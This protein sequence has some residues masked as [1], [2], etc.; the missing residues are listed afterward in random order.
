MLQFFSSEHWLS[1]V[2][3]GVFYVLKTL[4][5]RHFR[6][7]ANEDLDRQNQGPAENESVPRVGNVLRKDS[8]RHDSAGAASDSIMY[9]LPS[10]N[11]QARSC[12]LNSL[13]RSNGQVEKIKEGTDEVKEIKIVERMVAE[14]LK[15]NTRLRNTVKH[16]KVRQGLQITSTPFLAHE[17]ARFS[18]FIESVDRNYTF[19]LSPIFPGLLCEEVFARTTQGLAV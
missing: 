8:D 17:C 5:R 3:N 2:N 4:T 6:Q 7:R 14:L 18:P 9:S 15:E 11:T 12:D 13:G 10:R 16:Q 19:L 1:A